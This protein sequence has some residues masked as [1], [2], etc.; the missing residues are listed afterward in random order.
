MTSDKSMLTKEGLKKL[1][2]ELEQLKTARRREVAERLREAISYGDLSEN[3]EYEEAK[4]EQAF[5]EGRI[6]EIEQKIKNSQVVGQKKKNTDTVSLGSEVEVE[7]LTTKEGKETLVIVGTTEVDINQN[8][9]SNESPL[10]GALMGHKAG[11]TVSFTAPGGVF[12]YKILKT[13]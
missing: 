7:N 13:K 6:L 2:N 1:E 12:E 9:I 3:A 8:K 10:G 5:V 11:E 4:N